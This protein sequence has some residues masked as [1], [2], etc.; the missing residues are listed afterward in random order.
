MSDA[1]RKVRLVCTVPAGA[2]KRFRIATI[3][4]AEDMSYR[5]T[6]LIEKW[7]DERSNRSRGGK[8]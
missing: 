6:K 5:V 1:E 8:K 7:L 2:K 4:D 3:E